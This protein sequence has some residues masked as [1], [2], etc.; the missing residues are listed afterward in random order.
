MKQKHVVL[1]FI[2][3]LSTGSLFSQIVNQGNLKILASTDVYFGNSYTNSGT[4]ANNG[5]LYLTGHFTNNGTSVLPVSGKT[6]FKGSQNQ[7]LSGSTGEVNFYNLELDNS[8]GLGVADGFGLKVV[9]SVALT[10][11]DLRLEGEAQLL[12]VNDVANTGTGKLLRDQQG[13]S[14]NKGYNYWS[15]PVNNGGTFTINDGLLNG[16]DPNSP[17]PFSFTAGFDGSAGTISERW[18]YTYPFGINGYNGWVKINKSSPIA[19]GFGFIMKGTGVKNQ[20]YVFKGLPNNGT[21]TFTNVAIGQ[22][23]LLGNPY[24]S[25]LDIN[26][27][28]DDNL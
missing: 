18:L 14:S 1:L 7:Q 11:G 15:S 25:A 8:A 12:Q 9:N 2:L 13:I 22:E 6:V 17:V 16:T 5:N 24:P 4:H 3:I 10:T 21:Y 19:P 27:F 28:I 20:N 23:V 26:K